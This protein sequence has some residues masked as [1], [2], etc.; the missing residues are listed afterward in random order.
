M[1]QIPLGQYAYKRADGLLPS[2]RL[3]NVYFEKT[4]TNLN[5]QVALLTRP[6][7]T[8]L[9][10][11]GS[12]P[13]RGLFWEEGVFG[14]AALTVSG[15]ALYK[16]DATGHSTLIGNVPGTGVPE[17][18]FSTDTALIANGATLLETDGAT[19]SAKA[20]PD[21]QPV[22]SVGFIN[23]YG[24]AVPLN[25][26]RIY[27]TD[28]LTGEFDGTRF[29]SAERYP[30]N[31]R[32]IIITSDEIWALGDSS[33]EVFVPTGQ[34]TS[35]NPP[36]QRVEGRLY[37]KGILAAATAVEL[38]NSV[39]WVGQSKDGGLA[40]Y[41]GDAVPLVVSDASVSERIGRAIAAGVAIKAW[42]FGIPGHSFYVLSL[43]SEG[44]W[45]LDIASGGWYE[46]T[47]LNRPQWRAH[48]GRGVWNGSVLAVD[49]EDG[50]IWQLDL[51]GV[52]DDG[53]PIKQ[54][55]TAGAPVEGHPINSSFSLDCAIGQVAVGET[56]QIDMRFSDDQG[57]TWQDE[58]P[59]TMG[60]PGDYSGRVRWDRLGQMS[61]P[62][63]I[64]E[65]TT[66]GPIRMRVNGARVN[67]AW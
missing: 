62:V 34:D 23:G 40:A 49:D 36:F 19:V 17:I 64:Y 61:P 13:G 1:P 11:A 24:L 41:R 20:F 21:D 30:D 56:A 28:L 22:V 42:S 9:T 16:T 57:R 46:W 51:T 3:E 37:K 45:A 66:T 25:S 12:G 38:D 4:P 55:F 53:V 15:Q 8:R 44:T 7:L 2:V 47:S 35:D 63:R 43:G 58:G 14:D 59:C 27:Y 39:F 60:D 10:T 65:C 50:T 18:A 5:N 54:V 52:T 6:S 48:L 29:I 26:H 31:I 67:D 32:R 33:V